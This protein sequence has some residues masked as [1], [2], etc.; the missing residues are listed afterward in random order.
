MRLYGDFDTAD[1]LGWDKVIER[2][3]KGETQP[4]QPIKHSADTDQHPV[5]AAILKELGA[6]K[7]GSD[8]RDHFKDPPYG[9]PQ[10]AVDGALYALVASGHVLA[11]NHLGKPVD[12]KGLERRRITQSTFKPETVTISPVQKIQI[13][14]VFQAAGVTCQPGTE[15]ER[16]PEL[17]RVLRELAAKAGGEA[18][19]P[20]V[21]DQKPISDLEALTG[22][23]LLAELFSQRD[24]LIQNSKAWKTTGEQIAKRWP[25]WTLLQDLLGHAKDLGPYKD[26]EAEAA[27][28]RKQRALLADHDPIQALLDKTVDLL[29]TS[30]NHHVEAYQTTY[31]A[32]LA[33]L[34]QDS[35]WQTLTAEECQEIFAKHGLHETVS[36]DVSTPDSI[37]DELERCSLSQWADRTQAL[38]GRFEQARL[39]AAKLLEPKVQRVDLPRR[40][41]IDET[42]LAGWLKDAE[43]RIRDKLNDGPVMI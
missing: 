30:L 6:S 29:R 35:N 4:L 22:N 40:T 26:L 38:K 13:R 9:R 1:Q 32:E 19:K 28:I 5:C 31:Q 33:A 14:K 25:V 41:L 12:A 42:D 34:E 20:A 39:E 11:L 15:V 23:A 3:R 16:A 27:E 8:L 18:P 43:Q 37:L 10:D 2:A 36:V 7:K 17:L 21:P 24:A